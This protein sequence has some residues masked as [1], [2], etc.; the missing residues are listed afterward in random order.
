AAHRERDRRRRDRPGRVRRGRRDL[1]PPAAEDR[2]RHDGRAREPVRVRV[3]PHQHHPRG[4]RPRVRRGDRRHH[5]GAPAGGP[6]PGRADARPRQAPRRAPHRRRHVGP[7]QRGGRRRAAHLRRARELL[8]PAR[9]GGQ[10]DHAQRDQLGPAPAHRAPRPAADLAGRHRRCR[11]HR[12]RGDRPLGVPGDLH[13]AH[14]VHRRRGAWH[15]AARGRQGRAVLLGGQPRPGAVP[16]PRRVRRPPLAQPARRLRGRGPALLPRRAPGAPGDDGD[17]PRAAHP[18]AG[19]RRH[20]GAAAAE[21]DVHQRDQAPAGGLHTR[22]GGLMDY[23]PVP[24]GAILAGSARRFADRTAVHYYGR[25]LTFAQLHARASA[26]AQALRAAGIG[27]GDV[28]ALHLPNCPQYAIA[29]Y[30]TLMAGATFSPA[31]PLL[32]PADLGAQLAD[33]GAVA[34]VT[35]A[36]AAPALAAVLEDTRIRLVLATDREQALDPTHPVAVAGAQDFEAFHADAPQTPPDVEIDVH[37]D[38]AHIAY[39]GGTT[40]RSK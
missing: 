34:A 31:N 21:V 22:W 18:R 19:H 29:Y 26:F 38:L 12:D 40:G 25:D 1:G 14:A 16:R 9:G 10:R 11:A 39:T 27:R 8:H 28:V 3:R 20:R 37:A 23:P 6:R 30:G 5:R 24:V 15:A 17:V 2:V 7:G 35:W 32:P 33:C 13:A 4:R 36:R